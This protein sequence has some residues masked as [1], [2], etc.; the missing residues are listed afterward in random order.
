MLIQ[1]D[2]PTEEELAKPIPPGTIDGC[3]FVLNP[4]HKWYYFS[5]MTIDE[6]IIFKLYDSA[7]EGH[8]WRVPHVSFE[9]KAFKDAIPRESVELRTLVCWK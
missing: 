9:N 1:K 8:A 3:S 5:N 7:K 2:P 6:A 4:Q